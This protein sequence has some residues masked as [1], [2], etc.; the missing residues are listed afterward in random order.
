MTP[1]WNNSDGWADRDD[2]VEGYEDEAWS[3]LSIRIHSPYVREFDE[4]YFSLNPFNNSRNPWFI[5]FWQDKFNCVMPNTF[6]SYTEE[7]G[8]NNIVTELPE[9]TNFRRICTGERRSIISW[10]YSSSHCGKTLTYR[11]MF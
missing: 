1:I 11:V 3:S 8:G 2:V 10:N 7:D 6:N 4:H 9:L 5:E